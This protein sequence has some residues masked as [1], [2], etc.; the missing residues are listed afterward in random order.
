[1]TI[2]LFCD[3]QLDILEIYNIPDTT[4]AQSNQSNKSC[5]FSNAEQ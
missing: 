3:E 5:I 4:T 1:M 2:V